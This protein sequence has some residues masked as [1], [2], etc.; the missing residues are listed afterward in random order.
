MASHI[1]ELI[2]VLPSCQ[3]NKTS[4]W[5]VVIVFT[6][7][8]RILGILLRGHPCCQEMLRETKRLCFI[9]QAASKGK[10]EQER[11]TALME[12]LQEEKKKQHEHV[13]K[14]MARLKQVLPWWIITICVNVWSYC[15]HRRFSKHDLCP[16]EVFMQSPHRYAVNIRDLQN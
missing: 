13:E 5:R 3:I 6:A 16:L 1:R 14:V 7:M 9:F 2:K 8:N 4:A 12:K 15:C 11:Y 10:K